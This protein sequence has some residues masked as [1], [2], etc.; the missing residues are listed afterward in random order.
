MARELLH[1][2]PGAPTREGPAPRPPATASTR[3]AQI[4]A[5]GV[6]TRA[7]RTYVEAELRRPALP[8]DARDDELLTS[9]EPEAFAAFYRRHVGPII[10]Y[11]MRATRSP[12]VAADLTAETFAA[13]LIARAR[14]RPGRAPARAWLFGIAS[15][16][17]ADWHRRG[18][19]E[20][21]ARRRLGIERV[22]LTDDD[23]EEFEY[24]GGDVTV[25]QLI[26]EL[27][28][29]QA[30]AV[31]AHVIEERSYEDIARDLSVTEAVV[32][33]RVSRGLGALRARLARSR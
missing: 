28:P 30:D 16:K 18:Y 22:E 11:F 20:D 7:A 17:L 9:G 6:A 12:D 29:E 27:A 25:L 23:R 31:K 4:E 3:A 19:A 5:A 15:K 33:K 21:R 26:D 13:A 1:R 32:R 8:E 2:A 10:G 24:L 14:Y